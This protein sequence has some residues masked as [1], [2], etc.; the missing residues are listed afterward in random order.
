[1]QAKHS[2]IRTDL[3]LL[4]TSL[5][6]SA[7]GWR[8]HPLST[9]AAQMLAVWEDELAA[10]AAAVQSHVQLKVQ[11]LPQLG[12]DGPGQWLHLMELTLSCMDLWFKYQ[13]TGDKCAHRMLY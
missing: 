13:H 1:M 11:H 10:A 5:V 3:A 7:T 8:H 12:G 9:C 6:F 4:S 2:I